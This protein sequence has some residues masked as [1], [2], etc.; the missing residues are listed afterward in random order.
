MT[1]VHVHAPSATAKR[2][3]AGSCPDCGKHTRFM[4]FFTPWYGWASTCMRCGREWQDDEWMRLPFVRGIRAA[5]IATAKMY[6]RRM[7]PVS[8]NHFGIEEA[9]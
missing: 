2:I 1:T 7:P 3:H 9:A 8:Q 6:W 5:N 4:Q